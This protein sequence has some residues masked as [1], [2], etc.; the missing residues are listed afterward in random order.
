MQAWEPQPAFMPIL[1][2]QL[3]IRG[4]ITETVPVVAVYL[5]FLCATSAELFEAQHQ[6]EV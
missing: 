1:W 6:Q 5:L 2:S 4:H 3:L